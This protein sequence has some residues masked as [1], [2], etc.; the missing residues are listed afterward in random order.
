MKEMWDERF[1]Q[2]AYAYGEEPNTFFKKTLDALS[3]PGRILLPAEGEGRNAVYAASQGWRVDA[4][5]I[6]TAG[7]DK[8]LRLAAKRGVHIHYQIANYQSAD[9]ET[10]AYD[11]VGL[12]FAH[13]H[14]RHRRDVHRRLAT[15]LRPGGTMILE[16]YSKKQLKYGTGGP[17]TEDLLYTV[18]ALREDFA[19]LAVLRLEQIETEIR[20][21]KYHHGMASVIRFVGTREL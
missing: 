8:A 12:I 7:R 5:D 2:E 11:A 6:S 20:E 17:P 18:D 15:A 10:G 21:G 4:F 19:G 9:I 3:K 14:E 16:A 13:I 1:G